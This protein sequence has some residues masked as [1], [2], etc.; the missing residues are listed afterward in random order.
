ML[1]R[2]LG[3]W[4]YR[5]HAWAGLIAGLFLIF[6]CVTGSLAIF[7]PEIEAAADWKVPAIVAGGRPM[8]SAEDAVKTALAD[9]P[10]A[11]ATAV[12]FPPVGGTGHGH[13]N[14]YRVNLA[15]P[16]PASAPAAAAAA[17]DADADGEAAPAGQRAPRAV[18]VL[19]DPYA[20][21]VVVARSGTAF[22]S[23]VVRQTHARFY[24]GSYWGRWLVGV[25]GIV[26]TF[27][28]VS[29]AWIYLRFN[30]NRWRP[31]FRRGRGS[32]VLL[33]DLHKLVGIGA[34]VFNLMFGVTGA[35][36]GLEGLYLKY[37]PNPK[38]AVLKR[39][40]VRVL[41]EGTIARALDR[42]R[43]LIPGGQPTSIGL[44]NATNGVLKVLVEVPT[45]ALVREGESSVTFDAAT[46]EPISVVDARDAAVSTRLHWSVEPLHFGRLGGSIAIKLIWAA[47]G[48]SAAFL[49]LSGFAI[50]V[51]RKRKRTP[52]R[53]PAASS[54]PALA[55]A[56]S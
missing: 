45:A 55:H 44:T 23:N 46:L 42:A 1:K 39:E 16:R 50:Y 37:F 24:Y 34:L 29:G 33:A 26:L 11:R 52:A 19:V 31:M 3:L 14:T 49:S 27:A 21:A 20:N 43:E 30:A 13:G 7:K 15:L 51:L 12:Q 25:F 6:I 18:S 28:V 22:W 47:M 8:I 54:V 2:K 4:M 40:P 56:A 5:W 9:Y 36:L 41:P 38:A 17:T 10:G 35:V 32:R 48:L 53:S